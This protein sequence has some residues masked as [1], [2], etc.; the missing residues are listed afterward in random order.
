MQDSQLE[1]LS[2]L[3]PQLKQ[4]RLISELSE[5]EI[6]KATDQYQA[7]AGF[8]QNYIKNNY[9]S[10]PKGL[11]NA[12]DLELQKLISKL[13]RVKNAALVQDR[14]PSV[15]IEGLSY[16]AIVCLY[17]RSSIDNVLSALASQTIPPKSIMVFINGNHISPREIRERY[18][19]ILVTQSDI[20]SLYTRWCIGYILDGDYIFVCDDDQEPGSFYL[21]RALRLSV[22]KRALV[23]GTGRRYSPSGKRG[24][25]ELI[26]PY[27]EV[28][29]NINALYSMPVECDWGCNSYLF[30]KDW[31]HYILAEKRYK[32][33]QLKID[34]IQLAC[35]LYAYGGITCWVSQQNPV[36]P[37]SLHSHKPEA[38]NDQHA[39]WLQADHFTKRKEY[40]EHLISNSFYTPFYSRVDGNE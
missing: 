26:S 33:Y 7:Q 3:R 39:L 5:K 10:F 11:A 13:S 18:P 30:K 21:E 12:Y 38:G 6:A 28:S 36:E 15:D 29:D 37:S 20:N 2:G 14:P 34:D 16:S 23:C 35:N 40:I 31:I 24:F 22:K 19:G 17:K 25:Y 4:L 27:R 32:N 8:I 1:K 9:K